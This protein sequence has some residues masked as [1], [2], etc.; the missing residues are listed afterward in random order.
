[1]IAF[2]CFVILTARLSIAFNRRVVVQIIV[3]DNRPTRIRTVAVAVSVCLFVRPF[4]RLLC[5]H[6]VFSIDM[7]VYPIDKNRAGC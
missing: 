5:L 1:M 4:H 2:I 6:T 7:Y 3:V